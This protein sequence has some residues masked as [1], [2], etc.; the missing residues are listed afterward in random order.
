MKKLVGILT[1][2]YIRVV[3]SLEPQTYEDS[4]AITNLIYFSS[5]QNKLVYKDSDGTVHNLY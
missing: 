3:N 2:Y 4:A 5:T 1:A